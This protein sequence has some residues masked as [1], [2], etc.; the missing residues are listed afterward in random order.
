MEIKAYATSIGEAHQTVFDQLYAAEVADAVPH[1]RN[2]LANVPYKALAKIHVAPRWLWP[3]LVAAML[4]GRPR[5]VWTVKKTQASVGRLKDLPADLPKWLSVGFLEGLLSGTVLLDDLE[6][7][8]DLLAITAAELQEIEQQRALASG[9]DAPE[10][11]FGKTTLDQQMRADGV[12]FCAHADARNYCAGR[13]EAA[14]EQLAEIRQAEVNE[15]NQVDGMTEPNHVE[16]SGEVKE[17]SETPQ[18]ERNSD[19]ASASD[20][21]E[22]ADEKAAPTREPVEDAAEPEDGSTLASGQGDDPAIDQPI[23]PP[24][25]VQQA[26]ELGTILESG[27]GSNHPKAADADH[28]TGDPGGVPSSE[29]KIRRVTIQKKKR[30]I[31][32]SELFPEEPL[33]GLEP[34]GSTVKIVDEYGHAGGVG[35]NSSGP[36]PVGGHA[37]VEEAGAEPP[38]TAAPGHDAVALERGLNHA[39]ILIGGPS[40]EKP[41]GAPPFRGCN[42][43]ESGGRPQCKQQHSGSFGE[44]L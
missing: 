3:V 29:V 38:H 19:A 41:F 31:Q 40:A 24:L 36:D 33:P 10:Q 22:G 16:T 32:H 1:A 37:A 6:R 2:E 26:G 15:Q 9:D 14:R 17:L 5:Q 18:P 21:M 23:G 27:A 4:A 12:S 43:R 13:T 11:S 20:P 42:R 30:Q 34:A 7:I 44:L 35:D 8:K 28:S 25:L 39:D